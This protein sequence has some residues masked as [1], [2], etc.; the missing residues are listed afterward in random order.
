MDWIG[1]L[2][3]AIRTKMLSPLVWG[4][5]TGRYRTPVALE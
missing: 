3:T 5:C 4:S 1:T 2:G